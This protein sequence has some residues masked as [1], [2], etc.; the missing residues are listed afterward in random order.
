MNGPSLSQ[1]DP[2]L[3]CTFLF[4]FMLL[5]IALGN[6][7]RRK[8]WK[9]EEGETKGGVNSLMGALFGLWSFILAFSFN[10]SGGRFQNVQAMIAEE[11][12]ILR[13]TILQADFFPD[14]LRSAYRVDLREY[15]EKRISYYDYA[16]DEIK[17]NSNRKELTTTATAL[18]E[19][20]VKLSKDPLTSG[21]AGNMAGDLKE[22]F[23]IGL[24]REAVLSAAMPT[25][26]TI[27]LLTLAISIS[28]IG[29]F[30]AP[31]IKLK[32]WIVI[33]AFALLASMILYITIDLSR[34]MD[35]FIK[36]NVGQQT[37]IDLRK[38]F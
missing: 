29:G 13:S 21:D 23:D 38:L 27:M 14:S 8:L 11:A 2:L 32:D 4:V 36:P 31:V 33:I 22:L 24:K 25:P 37:I 17:F 16:D 18:W 1:I 19:R 28:L 26:I 12:S 30:T 3:I 34:P 10:Q 20:T 6:K 15:L 7:I 9:A 35:G 5:A